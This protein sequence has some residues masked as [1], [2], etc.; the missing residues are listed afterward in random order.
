M[1]STL[2][3]VRSDL[4]SGLD[5]LSS[6]IGTPLMAP[7]WSLH[8]YSCLTLDGAVLFG[9]LGGVVKLTALRCCWVE[10]LLVTLRNLI[11]CARSVVISSLCQLSGPPDSS[12]RCSSRLAGSSG[13]S[14]DAVVSVPPTSTPSSSQHPSSFPLLTKLDGSE[15]L[16]LT[17][18]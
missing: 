7:D 13:C 1:D 10:S 5:S 12:S 17:C 4:D 16:L 9:E 3:L 14:L 18:C 15:A 6:L 8:W 2:G 11:T